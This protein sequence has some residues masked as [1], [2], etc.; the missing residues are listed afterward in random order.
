M[1]VLVD[2]RAVLAVVIPIVVGL[3][4]TNVGLLVFIIKGLVRRYDPLITDVGDLKQDHIRTEE[5]L[6]AS[7]DRQR[8]IIELIDAK[9]EN[10]IIRHSV[11][12][13]QY[14]EAQLRDAEMRKRDAEREAEMRKIDEERR[15]LE[16]EREADR[17]AE[18]ERQNV[19]MQS[20]HAEMQRNIS[21]LREG[22]REIKARIDNEE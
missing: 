16:A 7:N 2:I 20:Q 15:K 22:L 3:L 10:L 8:D 17:E 9:F 21:D 18:R 11:L 14:R 4:G 12:E 1:P 19:E 13:R 6:R 5:R